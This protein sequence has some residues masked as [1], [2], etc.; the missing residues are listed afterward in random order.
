MC[1]VGVVPGSG[2]AGGGG[3]AGGV[4]R[5]VPEA[6]WD[7]GVLSGVGVVGDVCVCARVVWVVGGVR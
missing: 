6:G 2:A 7:G 1:G 3:R 4:E 5:V